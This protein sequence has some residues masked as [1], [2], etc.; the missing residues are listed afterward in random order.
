MPMHSSLNLLSN[1]IS[2]SHFLFHI[3][4]LFVNVAERVGIGINLWLEK[5]QLR[6]I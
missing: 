5:P 1:D 4:F 2:F 3:F 6:G